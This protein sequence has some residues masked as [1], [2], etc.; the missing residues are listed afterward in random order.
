MSY[1]AHI[2][3]GDIM[4]AAT[5]NNAL[6][7]VGDDGT[8]S[9][10]LADTLAST[11]L[12][13]PT[14]PNK[15]K[16]GRPFMRLF[17]DSNKGT[18]GAIYYSTSKTA[19]VVLGHIC[20]TADTA[21]PELSAYEAFQSVYKLH[22]VGQDKYSAMIG[23]ARRNLVRAMR[24]VLELNMKDRAV[25]ANQLDRPPSDMASLLVW[26]TTRRERTEAMIS[27]LCGS[28]DNVVSLAQGEAVVGRKTT[29]N[30]SDVWSNE[31]VYIA[32]KSGRCGLND[33]E[34]VTVKIDDDDDLA[35]L[36]E[37]LTAVERAETRAAKARAEDAAG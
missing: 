6:I 20:R 23:R 30:G 11:I 1:S 10:I 22:P 3:E 14:K 15:D 29:E 36:N 8:I 37:M 12:G 31:G 9:I 19:R 4:S 24:D 28:W 7:S 33:R 21:N 17:P 35:E 27:R 18:V 34:A 13:A 5:K 25:I 32:T 26:D 16:P 2:P